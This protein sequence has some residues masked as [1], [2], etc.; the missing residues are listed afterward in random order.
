ME[1]GRVADHVLAEFGDVRPEDFEIP[2]DITAALQANEDA[3]AH[4]QEYAPAYRR[5]RATDLLSMSRPA[6]GPR[7]R[8]AGSD[9]AT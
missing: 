7:F 8:L 3:W 9:P 1:A 5:I 6:T 4:W 2:D